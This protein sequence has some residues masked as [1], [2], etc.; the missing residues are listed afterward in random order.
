ML[1]LTLKLLVDEPKVLKKWRSRFDYVLVDEVQD[2]NRLQ[3]RILSLIVYPNNNIFAV[4][5][6]DQAIYGFRGSDPSLMMDFPRLYPGCKV[7]KLENNYRSP[8]KII[9]TAERLIQ[10]NNN[11]FQK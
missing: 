3:F 6:E 4:G 2:M 1:F 11:R 10:N 7:L 5:D 8:N 9:G